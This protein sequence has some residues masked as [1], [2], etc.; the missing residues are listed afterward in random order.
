MVHSS[1]IAE[2]AWSL[3]GSLLVTTQGHGKTQFWDVATGK[4]I[5]PAVPRAV[6]AVAVTHD[7]KLLLTGDRTYSVRSWQLPQPVASPATELPTRVRE[8]IGNVAAP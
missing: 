2:I 1:T 6:S 4:Q 3:D 7:G 5:G 8:Q